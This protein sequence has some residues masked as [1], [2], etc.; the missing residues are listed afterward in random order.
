[1]TLV[2]TQTIAAAGLPALGWALH[3]GLLWRRL[4]T[5]RRDPLTGLHTRAGWTTRAE[6][7]LAKHPGALVL[8]VDLDD[9]KTINDT[10]GHAA[11]DA[12]LTATAQRLADWCGRHGIAARLGGDEFA[13][14]V[15]IGRA[16][17]RERVL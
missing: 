11:G 13:A 4:A 1:M 12:V 9:F 7:L 15:K 6:H 17:C 5:A 8:L 3:G 10:H 2:D 14:I 16:S